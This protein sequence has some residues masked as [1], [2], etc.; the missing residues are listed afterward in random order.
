MINDG[1]MKQHIERSTEGVIKAEYTTYTVKDGML[2][3]DTTIRKFQKNGDYND[4][5]IN[6]PLVQVKQ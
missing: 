3:K 2:V 1:P 5:Y 4:S 6:E